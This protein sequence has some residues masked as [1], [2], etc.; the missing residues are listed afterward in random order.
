MKAMP[1]AN[2]LMGAVLMVTLLGG[3]GAF[4]AV[5]YFNFTPNTVT[6]SPK[7]TVSAKRK[8]AKRASR[9]NKAK[10]R[11]ALRNMGEPGPNEKRIERLIQKTNGPVRLKQTRPMLKRTQYQR[12][13]VEHAP[14]Q[15][16]K[17]FQMFFHAKTVSDDRAE[18]RF[19]LLA[20]HQRQLVAIVHTDRIRVPSERATPIG[21][22]AWL[23][24]VGHLKPKKRR[25]LKRFFIDLFEET[26]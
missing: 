19:S 26:N 14:F 15:D 21:T 4:G 8:T 18:K 17:D 3:L 10:R 5:Y 24:H 13:M 2:L 25:R 20:F 7:N 16:D 11:R 12:L 23:T 9:K 6:K 1:H 22:N